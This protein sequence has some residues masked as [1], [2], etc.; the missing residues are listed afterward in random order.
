MQFSLNTTHISEGLRMWKR[1]RRVRRSGFKKYEGDASEI[2]RQVLDDCWN[3]K[4]KF[5]QVSAGHFN[6]FYA[7]DFGWCTDSLLKLGM[8]DK[9][10]LTLQ[11]ALERY[12]KHGGITV[13]ITPKHQPFNFPNF[14]SPDSVAYLFRSLRVAGDLELIRSYSDFLNGEIKKYYKTALDA[15]GLI[16]KDTHFSSMKDHSLRTSSCYDNSCTAMLSAEID[17]INSKSK[18]LDNPF[19]DTKS[20]LMEKFWNGKYFLNDLSGSEAITG[21]ANIYPFWWGIFDDKKMLRSSLK[22]IQ[23]A[24][25]DSPMPLVYSKDSKHKMIAIEK[26]V[27]NWEKDSVWP[28]MGFVYIDLLRT[29]EEKK[30][31]FHLN[32]Y[33]ELIERYCNFLELYTTDLKP[34][35]STLYTC[36]E[37]LS[38][39]SMYLDMK[40]KLV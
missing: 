2:C 38:W 29:I 27:P 34:Y 30:A 10:V 16:R 31:K 14:Y 12:Q 6:Q 11:Y 26:L 7:R 39:A 1:A 37:S 21:D 35:E 36:D 23:E 33:K 28:Q 24:K 3:D 40:R 32:Q 9:V 22:S 8:K 17:K 25:L 13:A 15:D 4:E 20:I 19:K 18:I 5:L